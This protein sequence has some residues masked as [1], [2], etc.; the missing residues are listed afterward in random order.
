MKVNDT[1]RG[2]VTAIKSYGAF[3]DIGG[4]KG[5]VH[6]SEVS[7][8]YV[9]LIEDYLS[10]GRT[11]AFKVLSFDDH[12]RPYLSYKALNNRKRRLRIHL[13]KGFEPLRKRLSTWIRQYKESNRH[14]HD[15]ED[16]DD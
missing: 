5:L 13:K 3:V 11:Y 2:K 15:K 16:R 10:V 4:Q 9:H 1:V 14:L 6:I 8:R 7:D 12:G